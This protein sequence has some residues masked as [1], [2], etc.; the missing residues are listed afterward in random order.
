M[1]ALA[2]A[3][4][5]AAQTP[6]ADG[7]TTGETAAAA[8]ATAAAD[9]G[10]I[11]EIVVTAQRREEVLQRS[12]VTVTA[13]GSDT[14]AKQNVKEFSNL[15][16]VLPNTQVSVTGGARV[17]IAVRGIRNNDFSPGAESPVAVHIDGAY[18]PRM[19]GLAGLFY[20]IA[21]VESL[22]GP[23]GTLYGRNA[24]AG[25][26]N[27]ITNQPAFE[28][29]AA[30]EVEA[31]NY[32]LF[33]GF[34]MLNVPVTDDLA[35]RAAF[36]RYKHDGYNKADGDDAD[37][38]SGRVSALWR[39][40]KLRVFAS[41]DYT[42]IGGHGTIDN[43]LNAADP[44]DSR[45]I[46]SVASTR[47]AGVDIKQLGMQL[48]ADYDLDFA[49]LTAQVSQRNSVEKSFTRGND[50]LSF[51]DFKSRANIGELRLT[52]NST[53]PLQWVVGAFGFDEKQP[54]YGIVGANSDNPFGAGGTC[55]ALNATPAP[56]CG[57]YLPELGL[58]TQSY[59]FFG[60]AT[61]TPV[62]PLHL[63][64]GLRYSHDKKSYDG[65]YLCQVGG[66]GQFFNYS[67]CQ[68]AAIP[69]DAGSPAKWEST[70]YKL[71]VSYDVNPNS[72]LYVNT[73]SGYRAGGSFISP[74]N[75]TYGPEDITNY[76]IGWKNSFFNRRLI[77][78][79][80]AYRQNYEDFIYTYNVVGDIVPVPGV[81]VPFSIS[82]ADNL[83]KVKI[84][85]ADLTVA[86]LATPDDLFN[87]GLEYIHTK[88]GT[89][90]LR[91]VAPTATDNGPCAAQAGF[92][93]PT[94]KA[95]P[96]T[97]EWRVTLS[98][99]HTFRLD[100]GATLVPR[101]QLHAESGRWMDFS[102]LA[103]TRQD[104]FTQTDLSL[105][106]TSADKAWDVSAW[107]QNL[108]DKAVFLNAGAANGAHPAEFP[109][110]IAAIYRAPRTFG[111]KIGA[112]F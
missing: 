41:V 12:P 65:K 9:E 92:V 109:S 44:Y 84:T 54:S 89:A 10:G 100:G 22:P 48:K 106:W 110:G 58:R 25:A 50:E 72:L 69:L 86:W 32:N 73:S 112:H 17:Q 78:N 2:V 18:I 11:A 93:N 81:F 94:G 56:A 99:E 102:H 51:F 64:V 68:N 104:A 91:C 8:N 15:A 66:N 20:D 55:D 63:T 45:A 4:P 24:A 98:Y 40:D 82:Q 42:E 107:V 39:H 27:I 23:Q 52:S 6:A 38:T 53:M 31:G 111:V 103:G 90:T 47:L 29:Q 26:V 60:Q 108:E 43:D 77:V 79:V 80:D 57:N 97:P 49:T 33:R 62:D 88:V 74:F 71:G 1:L 70:D 46:Y 36:Q 61:Y 5:A 83:G 34:G 35:I 59:A 96:N 101:A 19:T 87:F 95:L 75:P 14:L 28:R 16:S 21:R 76:E 13:V 3:L 85:G 7:P 105:T 30:A 67:P 37:Q